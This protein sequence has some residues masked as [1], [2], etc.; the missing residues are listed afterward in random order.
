VQGK[1]DEVV[2]D[3]SD[4]VS[5]EDRGRNRVPFDFSNVASEGGEGLGSVTA[6]QRKQRITVMS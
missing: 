1:V 6:E 3:G 5:E 2:E 4:V